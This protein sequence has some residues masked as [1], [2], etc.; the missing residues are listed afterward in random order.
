VSK[1][2]VTS[3]GASE[4]SFLL[5]IELHLHPCVYLTACNSVL[6]HTSRRLKGCGSLS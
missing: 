2:Q 5:K 1:L 6:R 4:L 3:L